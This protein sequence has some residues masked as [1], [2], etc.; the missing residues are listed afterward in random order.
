MLVFIFLLPLIYS[1]QQNFII[2]GNFT[3]GSSLGWT[4]SEE[5]LS[6]V[7]SS[8]FN[9]SGGN[10]DSGVWYLEVNDSLSDIGYNVTSNLT[11]DGGLWLNSG[12]VVSATVPF[13][14]KQTWTISAPT[15]NLIKVFLVKPDS[16]EVILFSRSSIVDDASYMTESI[17]V[18][19]NNFSDS[20]VYKLKL[21]NYVE[22]SVSDVLIIR[23]FWDDID[24][25][26]VYQ[27]EVVPEITV[28]SPLNKS[29][30]ND[31]VWANLTLNEDGSWCGYSLDGAVNITMSNTS[32]N[33][34]SLVGG[35]SEGA[36]KITF[37]CNDTVGNM[38][39]S[40]VIV[41]FTVDTTYP[42]YAYNS[43]NST[44]IGSY[45]LFSLYWTDN[46]VSGYIFSFDNGTGTFVNDSY[47][48]MAGVSVWSNVSKQINSTVGALIQWRVYANDTGGNMNASEIYSFYT[49]DSEAPEIT[50]HSPQNK[51]Y[52]AD[53]VWANLTLNKAGSWC[54]YSLDGRLN[55]TMSNTSGNWNSLVEGLSE[56]THNITFSCNDTLGNMNT[57]EVIVY[58]TVDT[59]KP[60][61]YV[62]S[63]DNI[64]YTTKLINLT[65]GA[66]ETID[67]WQYS[68]NGMTNVMFS[69]NTT[70]IMLAGVN[71][72]TVYAND[73]SGNM[74]STVVYFLL[75]TTLEVELV[76]PST[77]FVTNIIKG[78]QFIINATV[79]C[80]EGDCGDVSATVRYNET[81][82]NPDTAVNITVGAEPF[83]IDE[84][85]PVSTK[86]CSTNPL[87][88]NEYCNVSWVINATDSGLDLWKFDVNF[89]SDTG[90][91]T[92]NNTLFSEISVVPCVVDFTVTWTSIDFDKALVPNTYQN[93]AVGNDGN[94]YNITINDG[95]CN[96]DVYIKGTDMVG[97]DTNNILGAGNL[98][99]SNSSNLYSTSYNMT[100]IYMPLKFDVQSSTNITTWYWIDIP[101]IFA[102]S[103]NGTVYIQGV[104]NGDP[105]P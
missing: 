99:W 98:T 56:L 72:I 20:G 34:N 36:H 86:S 9:V 39:T 65:V 73:T 29:Y 66:D 63:P 24:L 82:V 57:S 84:A 14:Y 50:V 81:S 44:E 75:N 88:E 1:L 96:T 3:S 55:V 71:N 85:S 97:E 19:I 40:E 25:V 23:N 83:F 5:D 7:G 2:N 79:I 67:T 76:E 89:S 11:N 62:Y 12:T 37:S 35:L 95:S 16:S 80:R 48:N 38:N 102:E 91:T 21:Y 59:I 15:V 93:P 33:W 74:N 104:K 94:I 13:S 60:T 32:G 68:L 61:L 18:G 64:S 22:T 47:V 17:D 52:G 92:I 69:P 100:E 105:Q 30:D 26:V 51:S 58:F 49:V 4:Y 41:Y 70:I 31:S 101:P 90:W 27:D 53:S 43:T 28:Q 103:Y 77:I 42:Q 45:V 46:S 8:N 10:D 6:G 54:G 78:T 87:S